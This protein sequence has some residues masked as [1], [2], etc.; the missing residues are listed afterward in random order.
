MTQE[1][2]VMH[3]TRDRILT[4]TG[5]RARFRTDKEAVVMTAE[6]DI[7]KATKGMT[8]TEGVQTGALEAQTDSRDR[9]LGTIPDSLD[10]SRE[11]E[12]KNKADRAMTDREIQVVTDSTTVAEMTEMIRTEIVAMTGV[13]TKAMR[14]DRVDQQ[15]ERI[16]IETAE[17]IA[18][19]A[20][21]TETEVMKGTETATEAEIRIKIEMT[22]GIEDPAMTDSVRIRE[23]DSKERDRNRKIGM[24]RIGTEGRIVQG[25]TIR[26]KRKIAGNV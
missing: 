3:L 23:I 8:K 5:D 1:H 26:T 18:E 10:Q 25:R 12:I 24:T 7:I 9:R 17:I 13:K 11:T 19:T 21:M 16:R 14:A 22:A 4:E 2:H 20:A 15:K 6:T